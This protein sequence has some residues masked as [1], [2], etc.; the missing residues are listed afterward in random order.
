MLSD[1]IAVIYE[2]RIVAIKPVEE[3]N[4]QELGLLM[5]GG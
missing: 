5:G 1:K 3:T 2:G 4:E